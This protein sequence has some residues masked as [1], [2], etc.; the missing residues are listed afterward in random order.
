MLL[1]DL[2]QEAHELALEKGWW[3]EEKSF[4]EIVALCHTELS[5]AF[6][7]QRKGYDPD[8]IYYK[9]FEPKGIPIEL[10]D[11]IFRILDYCESEG[12]DIEK[13]IKIKYQYN[14]TRDYKHGGKIL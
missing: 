12:I 14:K 7:E 1:N 2:A 9:G 8:E 10:A 11:C 5:E 6:E 13:A 3:D 4:G